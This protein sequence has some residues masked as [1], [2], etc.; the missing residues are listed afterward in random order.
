MPNKG[1]I[2]RALQGL[3]AGLGLGMKLEQEQ[4]K[5]DLAK[6]QVKTARLAGELAKRTEDRK[7]DLEGQ[8]LKIE[9][10]DGVM[11]FYDG[12]IAGR[13]DI[14]PKEKDFMVK[15][16]KDSYNRD[17]SPMFK[18]VTD[19]KTGV[20]KSFAADSATSFA[21]EFET[22]GRDLDNQIKKADIAIKKLTAM[23]QQGEI[24]R[25]KLK[26]E[27]DAWI[28]N[29]PNPTDEQLFDFMAN[30]T[31]REIEITTNPDGSSSIRIGG[32]IPTAGT[33]GLSPTAQGVIEKDILSLTDEMST[34]VDV[35]KN[36]FP[37]I[38]TWPGQLK[39]FTLHTIDKAS[40]GE[41]S[42]KNK[43]YVQKA[44]AFKSAL[45]IYFDAYRLRVTKS[46][47]AMKELDM[48][49]ENVL[50]K[51]LGKAAFESELV[52]F[53]DRVRRQIRIKRTLLEK[54]LQGP[55]FWSAFDKAV[56]GEGDTSLTN[57]TI[58]KRGDQILS[59]FR[60]VKTEAGEKFTD[61]D[62]QLFAR[63]QLIK[64]GY[65]IGNSKR[66]GSLQ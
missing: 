46:Q 34:L 40:T 21:K 6:E 23:A 61:R 2:G 47:A 8:K 51:K 12:F 58:D 14:T 56:G 13:D 43:E 32:K 7:A 19:E 44:Q 64:E 66:S 52:R 4:E 48:L 28:K 55:E 36:A 15:F 60:R 38:L 31:G 17:L 63:K 25:P 39:N 33:T 57:S 50:S 1:R 26:N 30:K 41:L 22:E 9:Q 16:A 10:G 37:P 42:P 65:L 20:V 24:D 54:G 5:I 18:E 27:F 29:N 53:E 59:E 45:G 11:R 62:A 3:T 35:R 49:R